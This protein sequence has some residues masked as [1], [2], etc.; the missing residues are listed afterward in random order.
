MERGIKKIFT[1]EIRLIASKIYF[2]EIKT[3]VLIISNRLKFPQDD[4]TATNFIAP[5]GTHLLISRD[6][7]LKCSEKS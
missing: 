6:L 1:F 2:R 5:L 7:N 4:R 3:E